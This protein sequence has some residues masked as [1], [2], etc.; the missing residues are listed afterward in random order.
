MKV[1][2]HCKKCNSNKIHNALY[3][4][5]KKQVMATCCDCKNIIENAYHDGDSCEYCD[6]YTNHLD[7]NYKK[8]TPSDDNEAFMDYL[9][10]KC[11][12]LNPSI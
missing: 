11:G 12:N 5:E 6:E 10:T 2:F 3:I 9:C 7:I 4:E 8:I 1:I